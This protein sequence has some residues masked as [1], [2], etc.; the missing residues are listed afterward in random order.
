MATKTMTLTKEALPPGAQETSMIRVH[1]PLSSQQEIVVSSTID[2]GLA[3]HKELGPGFKEQIYHVALC[4]E[5]DSRGLRFESEKKVAVRYREWT[6]PGQKI[7]LIV[8]N[9]VIVELKAVPKLAR[10]HRGQLVSYLRTTGLRVGLLMN[11]N[12]ILLKHGLIRVVV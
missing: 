7:D 6:I 1:S 4:L 11:F 3:V 9:V 5:L 2:C 8:E 12:T 10:L